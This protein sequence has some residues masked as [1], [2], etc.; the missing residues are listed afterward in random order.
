[1]VG[2]GD[3][4]QQVAALGESRTA[5]VCLCSSDAVYSDQAETFA[6]AFVQAGVSQVWLA[7]RPISEQPAAITGNIYAGVDAVAILTTLLDAVAAS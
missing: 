5:I 7:G 6:V 4:A 3:L 1:V 2:T